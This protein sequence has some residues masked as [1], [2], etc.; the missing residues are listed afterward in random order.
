MLI[1]L[2]TKEPGFNNLFLFYAFI[3]FAALNE[4]VVSISMLMLKTISFRWYFIPLLFVVIYYRVFIADYAYLD[5]LYQLWNHHTIANYTLFV[6]QGR[7]FTGILFQK[8]FGAIDTIAQLKYIRIISLVGWIITTGV[9]MY[10]FDKWAT[11]MGLNK[12]IVLLSTVFFVCSLPVA[13][14]IGWASCFEIFLAV[15]TGLVSGHLLF[16]K[17][18]HQKEHIELPTLTILMVTVLGVTSLFI[19]QSGFGIFLLP[20]FIYYIHKKQAKPDRLVVIGIVVYL[21]VYVVY[22]LLFKYS[23]N[24]LHIQA[25]NRVGVSIDFWSKLSY[26]FSGPLPQAF[27]VNFLYSYRSILSQILFPVLFGGWI[28]CV[29][30][31]HKQ[32]TILQ[33]LSYIVIVLL[34]LALLYLPSMIALEN[35]ASYRTLLVLNLAAFILLIDTAFQF[36][37]KDMIQKQ[38]VISLSILMIVLGFYNY[39]RQLVQPLQAEYAALRSYIQNK[40]RPAIQNVYFIRPDKYL[41]ANKYHIQTARD[42]FGVPSTYRDWVPEPMVKQIVLELTGQRNTAEQ[43]KVI[44]YENK[45]AYLQDKPALK[46]TDLL[47]NMDAVFREHF[48][49]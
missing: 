26:F 46:A 49:K 37:S 43:L 40:Y 24:H 39:N 3:Y 18:I 31:L 12:R 19:Y 42:E 2:N 47:I 27:T 7:W 15:L 16:D 25:S 29:F 22:Y 6:T 32:Q 30:I 21:F 10:L 44:Q 41:L 48:S 11:V 23:L 34:L 8:L 1:W 20:F 28:I 35:F 5:E 33:E 14:T 36:I 17:L 13:I 4:T 38:V 45:A 9:W